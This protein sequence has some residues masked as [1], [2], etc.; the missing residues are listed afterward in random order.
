MAL[1][2]SLTMCLSSGSGVFAYGET[3]S[4]GPSYDGTQSSW[5]EPEIDDA[6][7]YGLTYPGVMANFTQ[8]ITREEFCTLAVRLH[9]SL[10]GQSAEPGSNPFDDTDNPEILKAYNLGIVKGI[11]ATA[12]APQNKITRQE[13]CVM[14]YR[15]LDT[16]IPS[17]DKSTD[18]D[19]PFDDQSQVA[20][21]ASDSVRF[22]YKNEIMKG[23]GN[24]L[25]A[26]L[27]N[28]TREQAIVLLKR[29]FAANSNVKS[30]TEA[31]IPIFKP[32]LQIMDERTKFQIAKDE[33]KNLVFPKFDERLSLY[34]STSSGKPSVKP[35]NNTTLQLK[36]LV[37]QLASTIGPKTIYTNSGFSSFV[38]KSDA[39]RWFAYTLSEASG[40]KKIVWQVSGSPF[41]GYEDSWRSPLGLI[42]SGEVSIS[43]GEFEIDFNNLKPSRTFSLIKPISFSAAYLPI[44]QKRSLYYVRAVPV[45]SSGNPIGDPGNGLAILYGEAVA[46]SSPTEAI[47]SSFELWTPI[48]SAGKYYGENQDLPIYRDTIRVDPRTNENRL[49][50]FHGF[51]AGSSKIVI[52]V[53]TESFPSNGG[54]W[55][56][57]PNIIYEKAYERPM[58]AYDPNYPDSVFLDFAAFAK[59]ATEMA[60]G[61]YIKYHL[62]GVALSSGQSP[63]TLEA[64]YSKSITIEYGYSA[65][66][67]WYSDSPYK[68]TQ[69]LGVSKPSLSIKNYVPTDWPENDYLHHYIVFQ[70]PTASDIT[71]KWK[72]SNTGEILYPYYS[73]AQMYLQMG[74]STEEE[75]EDEMIPRVLPVGTTVYFPTPDEGNKPWYQQLYDGIV[76]FFNT[77]HNVI[78]SIT[79]Q[80]KKAYDDLQD[81]LIAY[82]VDMCPVDSLKGPFKIA[83]E[84]MVTTGLMSIGLPPTLPNFDQLSEMNVDYLTEVALTEAG[85]P[86]NEYTEKMLQDI[87]G[88]VQTQLKNA[89]SHADDNPVDVAF[90]K[91]DPE[92]LYRPAYLEIELSNDTNKPSI[93]GSF[94][95]NVTFEMGYNDIV[96]GING[97]N[98]N[99]PSNY[100]YGSDAGWTNSLDYRDHFIYGLNGDT[101]DY[102]HKG[103]TAIYDVFNPKVGIKVPAMKP[104]TKRTVRVY[105][106]PYESLRFSR[107]PE[108]EAVF[109]TD[110]DNIYFNNGN[111]DYTY[112]MLSGRFPSA[113]D[114]LAGS[115][116]II[117]LDPET[118]YFFADEHKTSSYERMQKSVNTKWSD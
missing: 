86:Q 43:S 97:L 107:Y 35:T 66:L 108:G 116:G 77:L 94:D 4:S 50:H 118:E 78:E 11:S 22:A 73:H 5:A 33:G 113:R 6:Y 32:T 72:N 79:N 29:T 31:S 64:S 83:L 63:G 81:K 57:T 102:A 99:S 65:P 10:T 26:P 51:D 111:R 15:A 56:D 24:R 68:R 71:C 59:S 115:E 80:V 114:Y 1:F 100:S 27:S 3:Q 30:D 95:L 82:V 87:A 42:G 106:D 104:G 67:V 62:R 16:S 96:S 101:V 91:L 7:A 112:F 75:Y 117:N 69:T 18:G 85:I 34:V 2:I 74:I 23:M 9:E 76:D 28:T 61:D 25:M 36:P 21:W 39:S 93:A 46:E 90:L 110:W 47:E 41:T 20:S 60:E 12:F 92:F 98:L 38:D 19:F 49:F 45:D 48:S 17:L 89:A 13:I 88:E 70:K 40:A 53:S 54:G 58:E 103:E 8:Y 14:I 109:T 84:G 105:L 44:P 55:P 37:T 52:Q